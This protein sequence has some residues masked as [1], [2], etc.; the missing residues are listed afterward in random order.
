MMLT[1]DAD[2]RPCD[3]QAP[4]VQVQSSP[5]AEPIDYRKIVQHF[6]TGVSL[7]KV[8]SHLC[9]NASG[10]VTDPI[11]DVVHTMLTCPVQM[12]ISEV[13]VREITF[14]ILSSSR[15][16]GFHLHNFAWYKLYTYSIY[17][18]PSTWELYWVLNVHLFYT[19]D[20]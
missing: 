1:E 8:F 15:C 16:S 19:L 17:W 14:Y 6:L 13:G 10:Q 4:I 5:A 11:S 20:V 9:N 7:R 18:K 2:A 12:V 3:K